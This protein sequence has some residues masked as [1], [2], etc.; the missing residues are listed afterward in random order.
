[1]SA[2]KPRRPAS[3]GADRLN[4]SYQIEELPAGASCKMSDRGAVTELGGGFINSG[5]FVTAFGLDDKALL[6]KEFVFN[7]D[8]S[9]QDS[10]RM[11]LHLV[12]IGPECD[13]AQ[14]KVSTHRYLLALLVPCSLLKMCTQKDMTYRNASVIDTGPLF[15]SG[16][17]ESNHLLIS[18]RC[19]MALAPTKKIDGRTS[20]R[21]RKELLDEVVHHYTTHARRP[22]VMRFR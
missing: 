10:W 9:D 20:F 17:D 6:L 19:F 18:C 22:G 4:S 14:G 15:L 2:K 16:R 12:E 1:M 21:L 11:K 13:H 3:A 8:L 5:E 7:Q